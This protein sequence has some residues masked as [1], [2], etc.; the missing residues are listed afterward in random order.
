MAVERIFWAA[1]LLVL[2]AYAGYPLVLVAL[3]AIRRRPVRR[4]AVTPRVSFIITAF[5]EAAALPR[6][7]ANTLA[8]DY[9]EALLDI[10]VASDCSTDGTDDIAVAFSPRI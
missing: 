1:V 8:Q 3:G 2:Y 10:I 4:A 5:N 9:P 7:L 6:K